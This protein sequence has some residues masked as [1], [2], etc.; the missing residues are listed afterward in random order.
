LG[1]EKLKG[2]YEKF[3]LGMKTGIDL[4]GEK[5]GL[6]PT[7]EWK[8]KYK[9]EQWYLGDTYHMAI[10]Q[11]DV[12]VTPLQVSLWTAV[13][14]NGGTLHKPF[15]V[16]KVID[17][18][19]NIKEIF[20]QP[21]KEGFVKKENIDLV[22]RAM[23]ETVLSGSA[24]SL[25]SLS[26]SSAGKTGTAQHSEGSETHAWYTAFAPYE[27]PQVVVTVLVEEGGEGS[28]VAVPIAGEIL[29]W[30]FSQENTRTK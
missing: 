27:D 18:Q 28:E 2:Y 30:Y 14:A 24:K 8:E 17:R 5:R 4:P 12:L 10:G 21:L 29:E 15:I 26:V 1:A 9:G 23:R 11:G 19:G 16:K 3:G 22:Q 6:I 7:P 20:P 25:S 13:I